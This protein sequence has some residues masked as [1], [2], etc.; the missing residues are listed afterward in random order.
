V[1]HGPD[2]EE[3]RITGEFLAFAGQ[4]AKKKHPAGV[5]TKK[6]CFRLAEKFVAAFAIALSSNSCAGD[7]LRFFLDLTITLQETEVLAI[8]APD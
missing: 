3:L 2:V 4:C 7:D 5:V 1:K 8:A 6:I